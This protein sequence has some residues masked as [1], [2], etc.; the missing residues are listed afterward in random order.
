MLDI[1]TNNPFRVLGVYANASLKEITANK[2]KRAKFASVGKNVTL[3]ADMDSVLPP[4]DRSEA[5]IEKA[6]AD[7]S[8]AQD[9]LK[10]ALFWFV[11]DTS[12]DEMALGHLNAGNVDK[13]VEILEKRETWS[14][15]LNLGVLAMI[16]EDYDTAVGN[17]IGIIRE[18]DGN[19]YIEKF[20]ASICGD[21]FQIEDDD[22]AH[23]FM[24]ALLEELD[25]MEVRR[26]FMD[27]GA[28]VDDDDY[29]Q[30]KII[31]A[32]MNRIKAEMSKVKNVDPDNATASYLAGKELM[33]STKADLKMMKDVCGD[34]DS[35]YGM[36]ADNL[37]KQILQCGINYYNGNDD[38]QYDSIDKAMQLQKYALDIAVGPITKGRCKENVDI[39]L[40]M[41]MQLPPK[42]VRVYFD[43]VADLLD[44]YRGNSLT[45]SNAIQLIRDCAPSLVSI[46][47]VVGA[48]N[49]PY[50][51]LS[52]SVVSAALAATVSEVNKAQEPDVF[53]NYNLQK[54]KDTLREAWRATLFMEKLD[55]DPSFK[56]ERFN[57]NRDTLK[58][59]IEDLHGFFYV[60]LMKGV[61]NPL[62]VFGKNIT[63][64][65]DMRTDDEYFKSCKTKVDFNVYL[66]RYPKGK[67]VAQ[68]RQRL[69]EFEKETWSKCKT[70]DD[71]KKYLKKYP[72]GIYHREAN[73]KIDRF[74]EE[75]MW[76]DCKNDDTLES[77]NNYLIRTKLANHTQEARVAIERL[78]EE[79]RKDEAMWSRCQKKEDYERY[80]Q[81][82]P[83]ALHKTEANDALAK[84]ERQKNTL[85]GIGVVLGIG[86]IITL[87]VVFGG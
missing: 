49:Y 84:I 26:L 59:M 36:I 22:V 12:F 13:A 56:N 71:F 57:G 29:I 61:V 47:E 70:I 79:H 83:R 43:K 76:V 1:V 54:I 66:T 37:A 21:T 52:T 46:K 78:K 41:K 75:A 72:S 62:N 3:E 86:I 4:I 38:D 42:E 40:K 2:T 5:S 17:I 64:D 67:H 16:Q 69:T 65:L 10:H 25:P 30:A 44:D 85:I 32:P 45:I 18:Y 28:I 34:G 7:L 73:D 23:I 53:G 33:E 6:F 60:N 20:V 24:D 80:L 8:L 68:A 19:E 11:K 31:G 51:S 87:A 74:E 55:M 9:K 48:L 58:K 82:F 77:Y 63:V 81:S 35:T 39:L 27:N 50:V 15:L 14:S